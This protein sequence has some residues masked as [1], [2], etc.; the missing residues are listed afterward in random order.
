MNL[1]IKILTQEELDNPKFIPAKYYYTGRKRAV[2]LI[3]IH[4]MEAPEKGETAENVAEYFRSSGKKAS[5]HYCIDHNSFVQCVW[6]S[7]T[8]WHCKNANSNGLGLEHAGYAKQKKEDWEDQYSME[9]LHISAQVSAYLCKKF[10][11]PVQR[12][13][14]KSV[15][16][17]TVVK[18]GF[19]GHVEVP[20]H[21]THW[22]PGPEFPWE[23]YLVLVKYYMVGQARAVNGHDNESPGAKPET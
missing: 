17:S 7:N 21:G 20:N 12:A 4:T 3:V 15:N 16:N 13:E 2:E 5:A 22:D 8:A 19:C 23:E 11:I 1:N 6:D 9:M 10:N 18:K 14:F